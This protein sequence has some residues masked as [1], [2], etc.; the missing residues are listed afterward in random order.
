MLRLQHD[1][2]L[3]DARRRAEDPKPKQAAEAE[4]DKARRFVKALTANPKGTM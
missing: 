1:L 2:E 3:R 4:R